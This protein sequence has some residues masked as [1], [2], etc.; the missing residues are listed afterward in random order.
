MVDENNKKH[1]AGYSSSYLISAA[2][3]LGIALQNYQ[4]VDMLLKGVVPASQYVALASGGVCSGA[5]NFWMNVDLLN[6]FFERFDAA[7]HGINPK[8][9]EAYY[10]PTTTWDHVI[11]YG[12]IAIFTVTGVLFGLMAFTFAMESPLAML[13]LGVGLFV[14]AITVLQEVEA[15]LQSFDKNKT[16]DT[17]TPIAQ[18]SLGYKLGYLITW[19]N[20]LALSLAFSLGLASSL[21]ALH[22]AALPAI[23]IGFGVAF[24]FGLFTEYYFYSQFLPD[25]CA[26]F[27]ENWG[28]FMAS[29]SA[30][31]HL[32]YVSI[33][34]LV[35]A[36][37]AYSALE[38]LT[39]LLFAAS[40]SLPPAAAIMAL[41]VL[42]AF[43]VGSASF[44]LGMDFLTPKKEE[45]PTESQL[46]A[47]NDEE[48]SKASSGTSAWG[49]FGSS[50]SKPILTTA[51]DAVVNAY[52][53]C[54]SATA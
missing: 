40:I 16:N 2:G 44:I 3:S 17:Q 42:S 26:N 53:S 38:L 14:T 54:C 5:V 34:A 50:N 52:A 45:K 30:T 35:N 28:D 19:G 22:V 48:P 29:P 47:V 24:T 21:I 11:Y 37:L 33:N 8:T 27:E 4:A 9:R 13:S 7:N 12:G 6:T 15:W 20:I 18:Q 25:F 23:I 39:T 36:A 10:T 32:A 43:F 1:A 49:I 31:L 51:Y 41:S 46:N